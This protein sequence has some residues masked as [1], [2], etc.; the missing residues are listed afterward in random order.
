MSQLMK[1]AL[2]IL[3]LLLIFGY[4][5][6]PKISNYSPSGFYF[7]H[8]PRMYKNCKCFGLKRISDY[9]PTDGDYTEFCFGV[10]YQCQTIWK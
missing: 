3:L 1:K 10:I 9:R 8:K 7:G 5:I 4:L 2:T 6:F